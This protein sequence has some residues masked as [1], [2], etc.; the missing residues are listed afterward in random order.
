M[1]YDKNSFF[2]SSALSAASASPSRSGADT[3]VDRQRGRMAA[4]ASE[5][6]SKPSAAGP[7]PLRTVYVPL[8]HKHHASA[9]VLYG[10]VGNPSASLPECFSPEYLDFYHNVM[11]VRRVTYGYFRKLQCR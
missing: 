9:S 6:S 3:E 1:P 7:Q 10:Q 5:F 11:K 2:V 4:Q 8:N